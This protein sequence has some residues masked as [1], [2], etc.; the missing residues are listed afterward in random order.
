MLLLLPVVP[1]LPQLQPVVPLLLLPVVPVVPLPALLVPAPGDGTDVPVPGDGTDVPVPGDGTDVPVPG[2]GTDVPVPGDGTGGAIVPV[3]LPGAGDGAG[4]GSGIV[5][6]P[7]P[8]PPPVPV[9][10]VELAPRV[11]APAR[12]RRCWATFGSVPPSFAGADAVPDSAARS[13]VRLRVVGV[14]VGSAPALPPALVES[15]AEPAARTGA[16]CAGVLGA[17]I[18][19]GG[20]L[21][22]DPVCASATGTI[23]PKPNISP[24]IPGTVMRIFFMSSS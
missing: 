11:F 23:R 1:V 12:R 18:A 21:V 19:V 13:L 6:D 10:L 14:R 4:D 9:R 2:D 17:G 24:A 22:A 8:L 5:L 3:P 7:L 16:V 15:D 20:G